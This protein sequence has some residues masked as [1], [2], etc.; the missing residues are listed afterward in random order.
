MVFIYPIEFQQNFIVF[1]LLFQRRTYRKIS[2]GNKI[3]Q[4]LVKNSYVSKVYLG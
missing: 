1:D 4:D 2:Y 3:L